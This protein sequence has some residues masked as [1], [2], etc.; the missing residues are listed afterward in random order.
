MGM[1][2]YDPQKRITIEEIQKHSWVTVKGTHPLPPAP[3]CNVMT[4][5]DLNQ[6]VLG[7]MDHSECMRGQS[8]ESLILDILD[9]RCTGTTSTYHLLEKSYQQWQARIRTPLSSIT[10]KRSSSDSYL[11]KKA[12]RSRTATTSE[13]RRSSDSQLPPLPRGDKK[14]SSCPVNY[15]L[16][17]GLGPCSVLVYYYCKLLF[18]HKIYD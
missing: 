5:D 15:R 7:F 18:V 2:C 10:C 12:G 6:F 4:H 3:A 17:S 16:S 14:V 9:Y 8:K 13:S 1:L 11:M